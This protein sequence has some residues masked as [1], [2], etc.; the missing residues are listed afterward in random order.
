MLS[1]IVLFWLRPDLSEDE[2]TAFVEGLESLKGIE[3]TDQVLVGTPAETDRP[4]ID[5]SYSYCLTVLLKDMSA[6][7]AYQVDPLHKQFLADHADK[8]EKVLIYDAD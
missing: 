2:K 7:D 3:S 8:W 4:V 6:H 1:H 5:R